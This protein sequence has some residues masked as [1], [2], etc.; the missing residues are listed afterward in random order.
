MGNRA[1]R[2]FS[3]AGK[4]APNGKTEEGSCRQAF[5]AE[6]GMSLPPE[7]EIDVQAEKD[8]AHKKGQRHTCF[9][10]SQY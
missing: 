1:P 10:R 4:E 5:E 7:S 2:T 3:T 6:T 9:G 8:M